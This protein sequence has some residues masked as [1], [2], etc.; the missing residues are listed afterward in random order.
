[1]RQ[2]GQRTA[3]DR[4]NQPCHKSRMPIARSRRVRN[5]IDFVPIADQVVWSLMRCSTIS[6][7]RNATFSASSQL[8]GLKNDVLRLKRKNI[9]AT[10]AADVKRFCHRIKADEV[11]GTHSWMKSLE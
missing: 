2:Y 4:P 11:F 6:C 1:M 10:I 8:L 3:P 9:S 7:C 5:T